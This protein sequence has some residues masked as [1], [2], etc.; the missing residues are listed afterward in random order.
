ME[1]KEAKAQMKAVAMAR[2]ALH[3]CEELRP[4]FRHTA[5]F[6]VQNYTAGL[7]RLLKLP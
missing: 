4:V 7:L 2:S 1:G 3:L 5:F 6:P